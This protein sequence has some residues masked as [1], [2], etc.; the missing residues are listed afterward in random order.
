MN[1]GVAVQRVLSG[2]VSRRGFTL[3]ELLVVVALVAGMAAL[4]VAGVG[5]G[6]QGAALQS[7]Q[8]TM[9]NV[10]T[11]A[12]TKAMATGKRVR[13]LVH[14]DARD[15]ARFRR[16]IALQQETSY[17]SNTW[18][19][20][21][22]RLSLPEGIAVLP[23]STRVPTGFYPENVPW[24]KVSGSTALH[25]SALDTAAVNVAVDR[26]N[27]E[28]WEVIQFTPFGTISPNPGDV[29]LTTVTRRAPGSFAEGESPVR[30]E[31]VE[32]VRGIA[33][34]TYGVPMLIDEGAG[35]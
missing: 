33:I 29:V 12:R 32:R 18:D 9:A 26:A 21:Y 19:P 28:V 6:G 22:E 11:A 14:A 16:F 35:F 24:T 30:A 23:R 7:A 3:V 25:S 5:R 2:G 4:F 1:G 13:I 34:S 27:E 17:L 10:V 15:A 20:P 31:K 8:A